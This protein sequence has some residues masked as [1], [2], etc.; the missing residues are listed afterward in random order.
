MINTYLPGNYGG[1]AL[2]D[3]LY[4]VVNPSGKLPFNYPSYPNSIV[5]YYHKPSEE[6][7]PAAGAYNYE[8]DYNP[9]Y[10]FGDGLSYTTFHYSNLKASA[11]SFGAKD[12]LEISV[13]VTNTGTR[14]GKESVLLFS[15]DLYAS[16]SPDV[17]RLR[18]FEKI[19]L[20]PGE[21]QTVRFRL[22]AGDLAFVNTSNQWVTEP[23]DFEFTAG[24][25]KIK[26]TYKN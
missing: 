10:E 23:G 3:I 26:V 8:S 22:R 20:N 19:S 24:D 16:I 7:N 12:E 1:D 4:G 18:R 9:Q 2:A 15:S 25:Q 17:K 14:A 13:D 11:S 5:N 6:Q 21:T